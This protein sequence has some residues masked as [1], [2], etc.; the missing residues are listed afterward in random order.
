MKSKIITLLSALTIMVGAFAFPVTAY[1]QSDTTP[2]DISA[3]LSGDVLHVEASDADSGVEA[4][5]INGS[6]VNYRV[7]GALDVVFKDYA[8][9]GEYTPVYAVDFAGNKSKTVQIKNPYYTAPASASVTAPSRQD[10]VSEPAATP[11]PAE[12]QAAESQPNP[13]TPDGAEIG[14]AHV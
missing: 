13:F 8:G 9:T 1:A 12:P 7:D 2:P 5:F 14:R 11:E 10:D 3:K 6:R 4:V